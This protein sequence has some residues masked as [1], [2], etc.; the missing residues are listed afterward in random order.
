MIPLLAQCK[1]NSVTRKIKQKNNG[2]SEYVLVNESGNEKVDRKQNGSG[3]RG[4]ECEEGDSSSTGDRGRK[5][6]IVV[7]WV[8]VER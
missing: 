6:K 3:I 7:G 2:P 1:R 5:K 8:D 4:S